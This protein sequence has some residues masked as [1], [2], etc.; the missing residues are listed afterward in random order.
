[1]DRGQGDWELVVCLL[2]EGREGWVEEQQ[3]EEGEEEQE[4]R[5]EQDRQ[6]IE[7]HKREGQEIFFD[8]CL[9]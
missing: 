2:E 3:Q 1:M 8:P 7:E 9:A 4:Q 5:E 6:G